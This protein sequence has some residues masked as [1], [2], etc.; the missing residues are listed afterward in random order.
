M[1][2]WIDT[3][4]YGPPRI[5][6]SNGI[7]TFN[8]GSANVFWVNRTGTRLINGVDAS[9]ALRKSTILEDAVADI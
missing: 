5:A 1:Y 7:S 2:R 3:A 6:D 4:G 9:G 8:D